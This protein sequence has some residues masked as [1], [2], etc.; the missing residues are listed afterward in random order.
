MGHRWIGIGT[1]W[2]LEAGTVFWH[3]RLYAVGKPE[4]ID[5]ETA[6]PAFPAP[7]RLIF[8]TFGRQQE[9]VQVKSSGPEPIGA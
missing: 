9:F 3:R 4:Q 5:A 2:L 7:F 6:M 1:C 8:R